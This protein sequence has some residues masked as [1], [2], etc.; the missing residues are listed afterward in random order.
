M[1]LPCPTIKKKDSLKN[2][3]QMATIAPLKRP[4]KQLYLTLT[5]ALSELLW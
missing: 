5:I 2:G 4:K 1:G 3:E